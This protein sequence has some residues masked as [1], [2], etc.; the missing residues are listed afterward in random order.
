LSDSWYDSLSKHG[1][2]RTKEAGAV[3]KASVT[4]ELRSSDA[5]DVAW[6]AMSQHGTATR[7]KHRVTLEKNLTGSN[8][9]TATQQMVHS[10][11]VILSAE[12]DLYTYTVIGVTAEVL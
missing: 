7:V 2:E 6:H 4:V 9:L 5:T 8:L 1:R 3:I 12:A 10:A 11:Q